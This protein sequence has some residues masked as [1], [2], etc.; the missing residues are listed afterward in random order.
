MRNYLY[1]TPAEIPVTFFLK[2]RPVNLTGCH[3]GIFI[4]TLINESLIMSQIQVCL[5]TIVCYKNF[6]VLNRVHCSGVDIDIRIKLLHGYLISSRFQKTPQRC[7]C[8]SLSE[9]GNNSS[10]NKYVFHCHFD[11]LLHHPLL[12]KKRQMQLSEGT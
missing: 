7:S 8:D 5:C 1:G 12:I 11:F 6:S 3:I 4:K 9:T 10:C 2:N